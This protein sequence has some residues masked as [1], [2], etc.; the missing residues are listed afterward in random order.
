MQQDQL[1]R[2][3]FYFTYVMLITTGTITFIEA[4]RT[5]NTTIRHIMNLETCISIIAAFFYSQF[6]EKIKNQPTIQYDE[7]NLT[8]YTDWFISTPFMLLVLCVF[9]AKEHNFVMKFATYGIVLVL[10]FGMLAMGYL[11]ETRV[12]NKPVALVSGFLFFGALFF[13]IWYMFLKQSATSA[14]LFTF[15]VFVIIWS[16]YGIAYMADEKTKNVTYNVLDMIAK[17]LVGIFFWMYLTD[18]VN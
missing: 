13:Y 18:V 14:S 1:L 4:L 15:L 11:G 17:C 16:I 10:N 12:V 5:K 2:T 6:I 8:R 7:I 3:S 9:L